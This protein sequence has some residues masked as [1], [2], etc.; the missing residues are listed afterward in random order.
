MDEMI[1]KALI[2]DQTIDITTTGRKSGMPRRI[3]IWFANLDGRLFIR[4][5][6]PGRRDWLANTESQPGYSLPS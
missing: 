6:I 2:Q 3:E 4:G 5:G 1:R